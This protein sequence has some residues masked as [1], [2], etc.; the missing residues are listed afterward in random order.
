[1]MRIKLFL[2]I[3]GTF[4]IAKSQSLARDCPFPENITASRLTRL[5]HACESNQK[6]D[7]AIE[8]HSD[9]YCIYYST[10]GIRF[11]NV[12]STLDIKLRGDWDFEEVYPR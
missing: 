8:S 10:L 3:C 9:Y 2:L 11:F 4:Q 6:G 12:E 7:F 5:H 1:M